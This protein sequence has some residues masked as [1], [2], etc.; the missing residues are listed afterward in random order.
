MRSS[1][2]L[3]SQKASAD[4][5]QGREKRDVLSHVDTLE[6]S[7]TDLRALLKRLADVPYF[8]L[9]RNGDYLCRYEAANASK[10]RS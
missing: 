9:G 1:N 6:K 8:H 4:A 7:A 2:F 5:L 3:G 10:W